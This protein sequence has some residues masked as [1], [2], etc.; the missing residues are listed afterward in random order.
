MAIGEVIFFAD[1]AWVKGG[2]GGGENFT[3]KRK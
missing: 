2:G 3:Y 1:V